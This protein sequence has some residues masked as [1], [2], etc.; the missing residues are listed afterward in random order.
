VTMLYKMRWHIERFF[1]MIKRH[2]GKHSHGP[3]PNAVKTKR[4]GNRRN[5]LDFK[6]LSKPGDADTRA[7]LC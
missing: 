7:Q 2:L 5:F 6:A 1:R 3:S 4:S